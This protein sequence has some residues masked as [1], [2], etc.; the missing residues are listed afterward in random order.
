MKQNLISELLC[1]KKAEIR[2]IRRQRKNHA[3]IVNQIIFAKLA[4]DCGGCILAGKG[5]LLN[6]TL[7]DAR[8]PCSSDAVICS[9]LVILSLHWCRCGI[10]YANGNSV[11]EWS[12]NNELIPIITKNIQNKISILILQG[13]GKLY[14]VYIL[15]NQHQNTLCRLR[16]ALHALQIFTHF[17]ILH[18]NITQPRHIPPAPA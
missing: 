7:S 16:A 2:K 12:L 5:L 17:L 13:Y 18:N 8:L 14:I 3:A 11:V 15:Y 10:T 9:V 4:F 6:I 1:S